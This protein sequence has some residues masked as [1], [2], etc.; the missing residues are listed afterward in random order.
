MGR[1]RARRFEL[2]EDGVR[3]LL[4]ELYAPLIE[5][6]DVPDDALDEDL[7]LVGGD[8]RAERA[9]RDLLHED[10][11][12]RA[13]AGEDLV[14]DERFDLRGVHLRR[15]ELG[16]RLCGGLALHQRLRL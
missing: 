5:A 14:W 15:L 3:E 13:I 12:R 2:R 10:R 16:A 8:E 1:H 4:A 9:R 6:V 11:A 7:V